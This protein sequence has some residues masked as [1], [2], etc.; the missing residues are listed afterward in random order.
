MIS[1]TRRLSI[2]GE[3]PSSRLVSC[4]AVIA[5]AVA[6]AL[7]FVLLDREHGKTMPALPARR[8]SHTRH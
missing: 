5:A 1:F 2:M 3:M 8:F 4:A 6:L 7:D